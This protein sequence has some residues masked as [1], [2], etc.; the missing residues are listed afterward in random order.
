MSGDEGRTVLLVGGNDE[1]A[2]RLAAA[3]DED[4]SELSVEWLADT[5]EARDRLAWPD[6]DCVVCVPPRTDH[7]MR[8]F[9]DETTGDHPM[10]PIVYYSDADEDV[11]DDQV[12]FVTADGPDSISTLSTHI[13]TR[14][15]ARDERRAAY[16]LADSDGAA[17]YPNVTEERLDDLEANLDREQLKELYHKSQL[18]DVILETLPAHLYVK[19]RNARHRYISTAYF[20]D[21]MD[22]FIG[23]ADTEIGLVASDHAW[24]AFEEDMYVMETGEALVDKEEYLKRLD[25]WNLTSKVPWKDE[26][27]NTVGMV[28]VTRNITRWKRREQELRRQ[29]DRLAAFSELVSHDLRNPLQV[30]QSA[31]T[32][33]QDSC[34]SPHLD[35]VADAHDRMAEMI[36]DVLTLAKYGQTV[37]ETQ[38]FPLRDAVTQAWGTVGTE[39]GTLTV[40]GELGQVVCDPNHLQ[41]LLENLFRNAVEHGSTGSQASPEDATEHGTDDKSVEIRIE[42]ISRSWPSEP[43]GQPREGFAVEDDGPGIPE[44]I[45]EA[46]LEPGYTQA[47]DGTGFGLAIVK[48][49]VDSHGWTLTITESESGGARFEIL[50]VE[51]PD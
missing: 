10:L 33:A 8:A 30:A 45:R 51:R 50:D 34:D 26:D 5:V 44:P 42:P 1:Q 20:G 43:E 16:D 18:F 40:D 13:E 9:V 29:N 35:Q 7:D 12:T 24:R 48:E 37:L 6:I 39:Q 47:V 15:D 32:L 23:K 25:R 21:D 3:L 31:L 11:G 22:A 36:D 4:S 27:G 19:D 28:G 38:P 41:R 14:L 17:Q 46:I 49:V 2:R